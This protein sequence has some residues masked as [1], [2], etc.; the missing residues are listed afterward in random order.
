M[1]STVIERGGGDGYVIFVEK[2]MNA[3]DFGPVLE[4][5]I[6][7]HLRDTLNIPGITNVHALEAG[8]CTAT[9]WISL[10]KMYP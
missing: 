7:K 1:P 9:L 4:A 6:K 2:A 5:G 3:Y 8:G 10:D